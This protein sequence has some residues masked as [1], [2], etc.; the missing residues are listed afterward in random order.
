MNFNQVTLVGNLCRDPETRA[1]GNTQVCEIRL[2]VSK[3]WKDKNGQKQQRT[4]YINVEFWDKLADVV[5]QYT[6]KG[7][8]ILVS[9]EIELNEY[10]D[11]DGNKRS[12]HFIRAFSMQLGS[13]PDS[14]GNGNGQSSYAG[15]SSGGY[16]SSNDQADNYY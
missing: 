1:V 2:A 16:G 9:G 13:S 8:S 3:T 4:M 7:S 5:Q 10:Q 15:S 6:S 14:N 12:E 11:R